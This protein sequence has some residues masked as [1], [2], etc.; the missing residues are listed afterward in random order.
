MYWHRPHTSKTKL[1]IVFIHGIGIGL[2]PYTN[3]L[4]DLNSADGL[5]G[6]GS[7]D[8]VGIIA[9]EI[10]PVSFRITHA[11]LSKDDL[12]SEIAKILAHHGWEKVVLVSHSYGT[13][14]S[15]HLLKSPKT[16]SLVGPVV[17]MD[18]V[19]MLLH[20]PDVAYNFTRRPPQHANEHQLYY[21]ASMDMSV[22]HT[23]S[24]HFFWSENVLWK[25]DLEGRN[26]T[27]SLSGCDLIVNTDAV[28]RYL[29]SQNSSDEDDSRTASASSLVLVDVA[30]PDDESASKGKANGV[31]SEEVEEIDEAEELE[32]G[33]AWKHAAWTGKGIDVIWFEGLDHAQ[34][35]DKPASRRP[36]VRAIRAYCSEDAV[37][38]ASASD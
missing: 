9:I 33:A 7:N 30:D 5:E 4:K 3:F 21:F 8:Q 28:A 26:V 11:A 1:P 10:M 6:G 22:A 25:E 17:L 15:T 36:V 35:F 20:L 24:R 14:V 12:C 34:V 2:Y 19:S 16:K 37:N 23:L 13:V 31:I 38:A 32:E 27:V 18:P 29:T